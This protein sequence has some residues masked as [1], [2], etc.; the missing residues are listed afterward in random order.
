MFRHGWPAQGQRI[1]EPGFKAS[2]LFGKQSKTQV[3][4]W[5][6][7]EGDLGMVGD[8]AVWTCLCEGHDSRQDMP[9]LHYEAF[10]C[11][12]L[13]NVNRKLWLERN[14][15]S[16]VQAAVLCFVPLLLATPACMACMGG[17]DGFFY[18][19]RM[20]GRRPFPQLSLSCCW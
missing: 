10:F 19:G 3:R 5:E 12:L 4:I 1:E 8:P 11:R 6:S 14:S 13:A 9:R 2:G 20:G 15:S 17:G 7:W 18:L 16:Q